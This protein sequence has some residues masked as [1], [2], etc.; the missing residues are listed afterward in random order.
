VIVRINE[1]C[2]RLGEFMVYK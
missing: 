1:V 2:I